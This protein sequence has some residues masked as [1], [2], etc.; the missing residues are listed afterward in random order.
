MSYLVKS[1]M[2]GKDNGSSFAGKRKSA[3]FDTHIRQMLVD[4]A[5]RVIARPKIEGGSHE[6]MQKSNEL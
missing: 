1:L 4:S 2:G 6:G 5:V 3:L